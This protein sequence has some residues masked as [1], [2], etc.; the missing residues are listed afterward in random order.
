MVLSLGKG[1]MKD[2]TK[3]IKCCCHTC[4]I[5]GEAFLCCEGEEKKAKKPR[6]KVAQKQHE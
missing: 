3:K 6:K 2:N 1:I 5:D 4:Y